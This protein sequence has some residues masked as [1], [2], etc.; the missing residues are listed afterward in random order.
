MKPVYLISIMSLMMSPVVFAAGTEYNPQISLILDGRYSDYSEDPETYVLPGF[1]P[2]PEAM[3]P[4]AGFSIGHSELTFSSNIDHYFSGQAT[5]AIA[6]HE[7]ATEVEIEEAFIQ[8]LGLGHGTTIKFGRFYSSFGYLNVHH[9]HAWDFADAPLMYRALFGNT[10][11]DD[12][13]Q[14]NYLLPLDMFVELSAEIFSGNAFPAAGNTEGGIGASTVS[15]TLGDDIGSSHAWQLGFSH[16]QAGDIV[17]RTGEAHDHG[18]GTLETPAFTG[19]SKINA[20]DFVYK[21]A[22]EG[23]TTE[24]AFKFQLEYFKRNELGVIDM[25]GSDPLE[26]SS[27]DG[28]QKGW[29]AQA[30]YQFMPRWR[31]GIRFDQLD[32]NNSGNDDIILDEAGLLTNGYKPK[33]SSVMLEWVPSEYS[34]LRLQFNHDQSSAIVTDKQVYVQYTFSLGAHGAHQF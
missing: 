16:W 33:R 32:V 21:W 28:E 6:E 10:L 15:L 30:V 9:E 11:R 14:F 3:L 19:E 2:G 17:E 12:G 5:I 34:R 20:M 23:N 7:G 26:T 1:Q 8:T 18:G 27:Y 4:A 22:P 29:Y 24:R 25:L 31:S 13:V